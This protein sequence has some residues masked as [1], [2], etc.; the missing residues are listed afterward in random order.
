MGIRKSLR[1][2]LPCR[3]VRLSKINSGG[4]IGCVPEAYLE[5]E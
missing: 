3:T 2:G 4:S 1:H 5:V